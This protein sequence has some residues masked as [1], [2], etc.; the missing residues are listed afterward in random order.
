MAWII[1][2][3]VC[4]ILLAAEACY[5]IPDKMPWHRRKKK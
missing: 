1:I 5:I 4:I 3:A 2:G